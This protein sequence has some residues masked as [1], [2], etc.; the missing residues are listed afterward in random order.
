MCSGKEIALDVARGL[1]YLHSQRIAH[2]DIKAGNVL[3]TR[4]SFILCLSVT[5]H[6]SQ[7]IAPCNILTGFSFI[8]GGGSSS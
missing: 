3:L 4:C 8:P 7:L 5:I 1:S 2:L 6:L